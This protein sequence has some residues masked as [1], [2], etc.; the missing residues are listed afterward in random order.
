MGYG[1]S[2]CITYHH[3]ITLDVDIESGVNPKVE[4]LR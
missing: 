1:D 4:A 3:D 2:L